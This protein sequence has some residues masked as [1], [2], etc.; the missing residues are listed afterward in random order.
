MATEIQT[1]TA[2]VPVKVNAHIPRGPVTAKLN[3]FEPPID[4]SKPHNWVEEPPQGLPQRNFGDNVVDVTINDIRGRESDFDVNTHAFAALKNLPPSA[5]KEFRDDDSIQ[6]KYYPEIE[7]LLLDKVDGAKRI[8]IF[9]HTV[10]RADPNAKRTPVQRV[11]IDQT[12]ASAQAR[13]RHHLP[14]EAD[15]LLQDRVRIINVWRPINGAVESSPLAFADSTSV[16]DEDIVGVEH[17]YPSRTGETA[18][19]KHA[20]GQRWWYWSGIGDNERMLLQCADS[21]DG[22]R[23]PHT[24]F[25]HPGSMEGARS[26]ESIEVRALV[27]G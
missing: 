22:A 19:V 25:M 7:R 16:M 15:E 18:A 20:D 9:D 12:A 1:E 14:D 11:H 13:V 17:R 27:F 6:A 8:L 26:R 5:E 4:G 21:R 10:R 3:F 23:V 24:A 2:S